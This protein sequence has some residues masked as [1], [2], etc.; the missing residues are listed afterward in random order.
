MSEDEYYR[1]SNWNKEIEEHFFAKLSRAR[2]Q[3][4]QNLA[5]QAGTLVNHHPKQSLKLIDYYFEIRKD[6]FH[7]NSVYGSQAAAH[8][9]L[10]QLDEAVESYKKMIHRE[11]EFPNSRSYVLTEFPYFVATHEL[12]SEYEYAIE[13]LSKRDKTTI[14]FPLSKFMRHASFAFILNDKD[15][16]M[17]ALEAAEIE[18]TDLR[19]HQKIGLVGKEHLPSIKKLKNLINKKPWWHI[20]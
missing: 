5:I 10:N 17:R 8:I 15:Q 7:D 1:N 3:K 6:K 14:D 18:K 19:Y 2:T 13:C 4:E 16:A 9:K 12:I 11:E 20:F